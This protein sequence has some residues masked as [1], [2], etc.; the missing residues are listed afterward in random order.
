MICKADRSN[1]DAI[2]AK[3]KVTTAAT[4]RT[5]FN[6]AHHERWLYVFKR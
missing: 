6:H 2:G 4:G 1:R 5:L 3:I